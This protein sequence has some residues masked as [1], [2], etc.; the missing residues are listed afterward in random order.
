[1]LKTFGLRVNRMSAE[2]EK[3]PR[4]LRFEGSKLAVFLKI[5]EESLLTGWP[6]ITFGLAQTQSSH[7]GAHFP[8]GKDPAPADI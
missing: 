3:S 8:Q 7:F 6:E 5:L 1:M 2:F 4:I